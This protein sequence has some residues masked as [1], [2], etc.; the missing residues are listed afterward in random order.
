MKT[1]VIEVRDMLSVLTVDEVEQ[2]IR[3]VPGVA[4]ATVNYAARSATVRCDETRLEVADIKVIVHQRGP[5]SADEAL[6]K[7]VSEHE[8]AQKQAAAPTPR[9]APAS[10]STPAIPAIPAVPAPVAPAL[11]DP[12]GHSASDPPPPPHPP[13]TAK[14]GS[15]DDPSVKDVDEVARALGADIENGLTSEEASRRLSADGANELR[16]APQRP[17]WR[18]FLSHFHDPLVYLS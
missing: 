15:L 10:T 16:A 6:P 17:A 7:H 1:S 11:D 9:A 4:S 18:R 8:P 12:T 14:A 5:Q 2:R 3:N 13:A